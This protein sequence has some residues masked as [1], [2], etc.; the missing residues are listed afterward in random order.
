MVLGILVR[1]KAQTL[2]YFKKGQINQAVEMKKFGKDYGVKVKIIDLKE[3]KYFKKIKKEVDLIHDK[4]Y[5]QKKEERKLFIEF[6]KKCKKEKVPIF[7]DYELIKIVGN[8]WRLNNFLKNKKTLKTYLVPTFFYNIKNINNLIKSCGD[9]ILKP[10][11]GQEGKGIIN[12]K[13]GG[14]IFWASYKRKENGKIKIK[15]KKLKNFSDVGFLIKEVWR[16]NNYIVQ[17]QIDSLKFKNNIFD[18]RLTAQKMDRWEIS[19]IGARVA[20]SGSFLCNIAAG[21]E[22]FDGEYV[23]G[24]SFPTKAKEI[25][26][27]LKLTAKKTAKLLE[28]NIDGVVAELGFDF[29]IDKKGKIWL[30]EINSKPSPEIFYKKE[31]EN[32][33]KKMTLWPIC[34][35]KYYYENKKLKR[36]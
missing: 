2:F 31:M 10:I 28:K 1:E 15:N 4:C 23:V 19:G 20:G 21:G 33:R 30:L 9:L 5:S 24:K 6:H 13:K 22:M 3:T 18:I 34:F 26:E 16:N 7:N 25:I 36:N 17:P 14:K 27:E 35:A 32:I 29:M 12:L 11:W 8:K